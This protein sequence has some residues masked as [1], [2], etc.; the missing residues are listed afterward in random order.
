MI[1]KLRYCLEMSSV[2]NPELGRLGRENR[3]LKIS[4]NIS[5]L[6]CYPTTKQLH[7]LEYITTLQVSAGQY[8]ELPTSPIMTKHC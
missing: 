5:D 6:I 3:R 1:H 7:T 8:S 4:T 2:N